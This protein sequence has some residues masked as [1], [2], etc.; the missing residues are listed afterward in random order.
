MFGVECKDISHI[1]KVC[2][3]QSFATKK[4]RQHNSETVVGEVV[5]IFEIPTATKTINMIIPNDC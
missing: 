2:T 4:V 5:G 3:G 1:S